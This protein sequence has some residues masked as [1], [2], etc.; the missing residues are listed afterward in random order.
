MTRVH[1]TFF[2]IFFALAICSCRFEALGAEN[3]ESSQSP[4]MSGAESVAYPSPFMPDGVL[5][6]FPFGTVLRDSIWSRAEWGPKTEKPIEVCWENPDAAPARY[7]DVVEKAV[8]DTWERVSLVKFIWS[9]SCPEK[10][11][12]VRIRIGDE[13]PHVNAL[14]KYLE[15]MPGGMV[16]NF[17]FE[18]WGTGCQTTKDFCAAAIGVHE[19][20]HALGFAHE[21]NRDDAPFECRSEA[22]GTNGNWNITTYDPDSIMNYCN[23]IWNNNGTLSQRD[24]DAVTQLYGK[25]I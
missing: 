10:S 3:A 5:T 20:G 1:Q 9:R 25:R 12:G 4:F 13:G 18:K 21:Q 22:Q 2:V 23:A 15:N 24:I 16:L 7:L 6:V 19:F 14:G 17:Q 8:K 11:H